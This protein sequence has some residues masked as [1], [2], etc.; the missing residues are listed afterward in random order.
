[1]RIH[2]AA[3]E[4]QLV[5]DVWIGVS[6]RN[7]KGNPFL[8]RGQRFPTDLGAVSGSART[9]TVLC[10]RSRVSARITSQEAASPS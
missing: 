9:S 8:G 4:E 6:G 2:G 5:C 7:E 10:W 1:M 3:G